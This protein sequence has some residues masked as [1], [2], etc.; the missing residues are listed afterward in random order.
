MTRTERSDLD[1][2]TGLLFGDDGQ[3]G[4]FA[5]IRGEITSLREEFK[6]ALVFYQ[7][8]SGVLAVGK[9]L[10]PTGVAGVIIGILW[11]AGIVHL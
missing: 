2:L 6:P 5:A 9:W 7:R 3:G 8:A 1:K 10:G 11:V 4:E